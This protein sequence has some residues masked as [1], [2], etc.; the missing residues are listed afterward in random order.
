M[1]EIDN[2]LRALEDY[3]ASQLRPGFAQY[4][5]NRARAIPAPVFAWGRTTLYAAAACGLACGLLL[6]ASPRDQSL[7]QWQDIVDSTQEI[8]GGY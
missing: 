1:S 2:T 4:V 7:S 5:L 3:A 8:D 6:L